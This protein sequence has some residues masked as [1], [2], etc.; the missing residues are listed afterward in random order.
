MLPF[1]KRVI[2]RMPAGVKEDSM[3]ENN[4]IVKGYCFGTAEDAE[5]ARQEEKKIEYLEQHMDLGKT[6][7]MLLVY[8]KAVESRIFVTPVGWEYLKRLQ[9]ELNS[10]A[11]LM[12]EVPPVALYTVFAH[13]VGDNI[14]IPEPRIQ[15]KTKSNTKKSLIISVIMNIVLAIAVGGM[16]YIAYTSDNPNVLN[17][18]R[19]LVNKYA[20]WEQELSEREKVIREKER[21]LMID[22]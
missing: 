7:N 13:R 1:S 12:E 10:R 15:E 20:Q 11:D 19:N 9:R 14:R 5:T 8:K 4:N 6:E 3:S 17:Y 16:F 2:Y 22:E 18:K 21:N